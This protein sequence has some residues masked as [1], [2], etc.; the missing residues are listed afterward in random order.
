MDYTGRQPFPLMRRPQGRCAPAVIDETG[1]A[2]LLP[3]QG[4]GA[5]MGADFQG[6]GGD[7]DDDDLGADDDLGLDDVGEDGLGGDL[8]DKIEKAERKIQKAKRRYSDMKGLWQKARKRRLLR[9]IEKAEDDLRDLKRQKAKEAA[10]LA[11]ALTPG[12]GG[13]GPVASRGAI[14]NRN[15]R[16]TQ[17]Q[18][19]AVRRGQAANG[20]QFN[21]VAPPGSGRLVRLPFYGTVAPTN[22]PRTSFTA[23]APGLTASSTLT[24]EDVSYAVTQIV[25]FTAQVNV[26]SVNG[27]P[28]NASQAFVE[29]LKTQGNA[30]LFLHE[31]S[32]D[33]SMYDCDDEHLLGLRSYP[34]LRSPNRGTVSAAGFIGVANDMVILSC[35]LVLDV[36]EDDVF[37]PGVSGPYAG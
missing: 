23:G 22:I 30:N 33:A 13:A 5:Q 1:A 6:F 19:E 3:Q 31:N 14:V 24:T 29:D 18:G 36:I 25:G 34:Y 21:V 10:A 12:G 8:D 7:D 2:F 9:K 32:A 17:G 11:A 20:M 16:I 37:G 35:S 15:Q 28:S 4:G 27:I 26:A